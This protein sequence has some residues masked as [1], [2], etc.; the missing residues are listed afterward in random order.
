LQVTP[1]VSSLDFANGLTF[2]GFHMPAV[3]TRRVQTEIELESGQTFAIGGLLDNRVV[4]TWSK[5]PGIGD[6]PLLGKIFQSY[7]RSK[8]NSELL[9]MVTPELVRPVPSDQQMPQIPMPQPWLEGTASQPPRTPAISATGLVPNKPPRTV[10]PVEEMIQSLR[11]AAE[12]SAAPALAPAAAVPNPP[13]AEP[14]PT[15]AAPAAPAPKQAAAPAA[16]RN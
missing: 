5:V 12:P 7:S 4:E 2:Q 15:Q 16:V 8:N 14:A 6:I 10:I 9:I 11:P 3:S 13:A 1:E